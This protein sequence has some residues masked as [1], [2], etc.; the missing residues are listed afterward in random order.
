[1]SQPILALFLYLVLV[2]EGGNGSFFKPLT[3]R[4][5]STAKKICG[6]EAEIFYPHQCLLKGCCYKNNSCY[7]H[8]LDVDKQRRNAG[9][10]GGILIIMTIT[11]CIFFCWKFKELQ[12][13]EKMSR[14]SRGGSEMADYLVKLLD[15]ESEADDYKGHELLD[16]WAQGSYSPEPG[17]GKG[18][19]AEQQWS[20]ELGSEA[21][22]EPMQ[23]VEPEPPKPEAA[24]AAGTSAPSEPPPPPAPAPPPSEAAPPPPPPEGAPPPPPPPSGEPAPAPP[25]APPSGDSGGAP[26]PPPPPPPGEPPPAPPPPPP[27]EPPPAP[28]PPPS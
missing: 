9:I 2:L 8:V 23:P 10:L 15:E 4:L 11:M 28:P 26:P 5:E 25:P 7:F 17:G 27:A 21:S 6:G 20:P 22:P 13:K 16:S 3:C 19:L 12:R 14:T 24:P 18:G 1:M